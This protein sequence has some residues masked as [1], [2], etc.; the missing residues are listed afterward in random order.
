MVEFSRSGGKDITSLA[1]VEKS[2]K[3]VDVVIHAAAELDETKKEEEIYKTNVQGTRNVITAAEEE[4]IDQLIFVSSVAVYPEANQKLDEKSETGPITPYG[5]SKKEAEELVWNMQEL[6]PVTII[7]PALV[8]GPNTY[9]KGIFKTIKKGFP[10]IGKGENAWQMIDVDDLTD[11]ISL[12]VGNEDA[13]NER[14]VVAEKET[15]TLREVVDMIAEIEGVKKPGTIPKPLG[16][17]ISH[18]F[19][20]QG[21]LTG[22]KP[23]LIPAHVKRLFKHREYDITKAMKLGWKP[24][25]STNESLQKTYDELNSMK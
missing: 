24:K 16:I 4:G 9:W 15:H 1:D 10:L 14:Y 25:H 5:H 12:C 13:Y 19:G 2:I 3:G 8:V 20:L 17:A 18:I 7:R 21:K 23:L 11:F 6:F 22:K